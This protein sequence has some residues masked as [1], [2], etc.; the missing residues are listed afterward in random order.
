MLVFMCLHR[1]YLHDLARALQPKKSM[2]HMAVR[3]HV[4]FGNLTNSQEGCSA[5]ATDWCE[6]RYYH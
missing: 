2:S 4:D 5:V 1:D 6:V 3:Y